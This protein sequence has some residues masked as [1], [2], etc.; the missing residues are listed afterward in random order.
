MADKAIILL[1]V[2]APIGGQVK[3]RLAA[4]MG[5]ETALDLYRCFV[6]DIVNTLDSSGYPFRI[7]YYPHDGDSALATLLGRRHHVMPQKGKDLGTRMENAFRQI[8]SEGYGRAILIGSDIPDLTPAVFRE[9]LDSLENNDVVIGPAAD[10]GYYLIGFHKRSLLPPLFH[11]REWSTN[12][13]F[14][15]ALEILRDA[16]LRIHLAPEWGDVDTK[17]DLTALAARSR[18]T[19]F[20]KSRTMAYLREKGFIK[21]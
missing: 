16:S 21:T 13:V 2:K 19:I 17:E 8:F 3:S 4:E 18:G 9:A 6:L 14:R 10:G 20:D 12:R 1:F 5:E 11:E 7:L 15:E